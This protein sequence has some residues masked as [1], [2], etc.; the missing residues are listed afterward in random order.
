MS[1]YVHPILYAPEQIEKDLSSALAAWESL[2]E[3]DRKKNPK[4]YAKHIEVNWDAKP[5]EGQKGSRFWN[6]KTTFGGKQGRPQ[7]RF[8][9]EI[10][11]NTIIPAEEKDFSRNEEKKS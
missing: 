11:G 10:N 8:T 2:S 5:F 7:L 4:W 9:K 3:D 1:S 6:I